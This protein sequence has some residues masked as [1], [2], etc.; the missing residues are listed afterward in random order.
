MKNVSQH[1]SLN[2]TLYLLTRSLFEKFPAA[3]I[4]SSDNKNTCDIFDCSVFKTTV[5]HF[6]SFMHVVSRKGKKATGLD[7]QAYCN[8]T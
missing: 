2:E 6:N 4:F 8:S 7:Y 5:V 3:D 1:V